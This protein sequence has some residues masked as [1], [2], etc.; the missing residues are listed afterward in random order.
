MTAV[1]GIGRLA[2]RLM[3]MGMVPGATV[4]VLRKAPLGDPV[5]YRVRGA[6]ISMRSAEA[7][8]ISVCAE[9]EFS[10]QDLP[11]S[12]RDSSRLALVAG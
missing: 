7:A 6:V 4:N 12:M 9:T 2:A 11:D 10:R 3:E 8:C 1:A 5:Q